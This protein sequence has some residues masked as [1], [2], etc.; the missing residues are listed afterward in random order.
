[1]TSLLLVTV[2]AGAALAEPTKLA[3]PE[4]HAARP[5]TRDCNAMFG[6][7][8]SAAGFGISSGKI[9]L[10][11]RG[12]GG[13]TEEVAAQVGRARLLPAFDV[14]LGGASALFRFVF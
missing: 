6:G 8:M 9:V 5:P 10:L 7:I 2:L 11:R 1:M 13:R 14:G 4:L 12:A 3:I